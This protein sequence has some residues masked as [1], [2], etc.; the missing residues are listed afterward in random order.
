MKRFPITE[1][2]KDKGSLR[3]LKGEGNFHV[4]LCLMFLYSCLSLI[5]EKGHPRNIKLG[6][7]EGESPLDGLGRD[8]HHWFQKPFVVYFQTFQV[9]RPPLG[10]AGRC[11]L[12]RSV[13]QGM[14]LGCADL[15]MQGIVPQQL[16][17][18]ITLFPWP[19]RYLLLWT[20]FLMLLWFQRQK[21]CGLLAYRAK[22]K[23]EVLVQ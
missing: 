20:C 5:L 19:L 12:S 2:W 22:R 17:E 4:C 10:S 16:L 13:S 1:R 3:P 18:T 23:H 11:S 6:I 8:L 7:K 21:A 14:M 15:L 9:D